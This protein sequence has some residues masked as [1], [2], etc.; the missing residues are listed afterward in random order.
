MSRC[1]RKAG[2]SACSSTSWPGPISFESPETEI[3]TYSY[4]ETGELEEIAV[5]AGPAER[6]T[7]FGYDAL[8]RLETIEDVE[9]RIVSFAYDGANRVTSTLLPD[10]NTVG[11]SYDGN[12]NVESV[13]PPGKPVHVFGYTER[14]QL[15]TYTLPDAGSGTAVE[16]RVYDDSKR[17]KEVRRPDARIRSNTSTTTTIS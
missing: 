3:W 8:H 13:T 5:G 6:K 11:F 15:E 10:L 1:H 14:N 9:H 12:G 4:L 16:Q 2:R 17:L 7:T